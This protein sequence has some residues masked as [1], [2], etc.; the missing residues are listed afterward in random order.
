VT[1]GGAAAAV[2]K[3]S[4]E[5]MLWVEEV[6]DAIVHRRNGARKQE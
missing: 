6:V 3:R 4:R 2:A 5:P 1:W